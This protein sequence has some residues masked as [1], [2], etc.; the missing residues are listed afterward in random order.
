MR[1]GLAGA[2]ETSIEE[3]ARNLHASKSTVNEIEVRAL[4][5]LRYPFR[6]LSGS[7]RSV[8]DLQRAINIFEHIQKET[9]TA[10][11]VASKLKDELPELSS[12]ADVLPKNR[13][14]LYAFVQTLVLILTLL[15]AIANR[16]QSS[17]VQIQQTTNVV[18]VQPEQKEVVKPKPK[19]PKKTSKGKKK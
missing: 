3:I 12:L 14:E 6:L 10:E 19:A 2:P 16:T 13:Q 4:R 8:A 9:I 18:V 11:E 7:G 17:N 15:V 1:F 5:K